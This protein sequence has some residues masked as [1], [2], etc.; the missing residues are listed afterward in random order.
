MKT[1]EAFLDSINQ[2]IVNAE[3]QAN[4]VPRMGMNVY[5][6]KSTMV[7]QQFTDPNSFKHAQKIT[8]R[9][10][11][12]STLRNVLDGNGSLQAKKI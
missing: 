3:K 4:S 5:L 2:S 12:S 6:D 1:A 11:Q 7:M 8:A 10:G 9:K